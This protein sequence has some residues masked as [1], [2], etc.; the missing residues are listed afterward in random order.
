[1][2]GRAP[3]ATWRGL[4]ILACVACLNPQPDDGPLA[5]PD[6]TTDI[7]ANGNTGS[8]TVTPSVDAEAPAQTSNAGQTDTL[9]GDTAAQQPSAPSDQGPDAGMEPSDAG[10]SLPDGGT[11]DN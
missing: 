6:S 10:A 11:A 3:A 7:P 4:A 9:P 8:S 1:M 5:R 2:K